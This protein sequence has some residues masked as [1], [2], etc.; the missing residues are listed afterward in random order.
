M[1]QDQMAASPHYQ[2]DGTTEWAALRRRLDRDCPD[3]A[4]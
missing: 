4:S 2:Y 1:I 3:Y